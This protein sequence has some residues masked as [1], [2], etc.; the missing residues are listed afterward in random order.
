[1]TVLDGRFQRK[2]RKV[3]PRPLDFARTGTCAAWSFREENEPT[4]RSM[5]WFPAAEQRDGLGLTLGARYIERR[6]FR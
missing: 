1:M 6:P 4:A 2:H 3:R 5:S